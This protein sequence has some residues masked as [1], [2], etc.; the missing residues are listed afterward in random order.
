M[1]RTPDR[2]NNGIRF[3][4]TDDLGYF[5]IDGYEGHDYL[6]GAFTDSRDGNERV[7]AKATIVSV[8]PGNPLKPLLLTLNKNNTD[9]NFWDF[10]TAKSL[11]K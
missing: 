5:S 2:K 1:A 11:K 8:L 3:I 4:K 7:E 6:I 9:E 10:P